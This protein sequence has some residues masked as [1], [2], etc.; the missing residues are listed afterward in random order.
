MSFF[1]HEDRDGLTTA[2]ADL[3]ALRGSPPPPAEFWP[4]LLAALSRACGAG[5]SV[6]LL[7]KDGADGWQKFADW[8]S[9]NERGAF[10]AEFAQTAP[11]L[12]DEAVTSGSALAELG[13][14]A[15]GRGDWVAVVRLLS[16]SD[17][18]RCVMACLLRDATPETARDRVARLL[19]LA[20]APAVCEGRIQLQRA[21][22]DV[23]RFSS[24]VDLMLAMRC[25]QRFLAA[26][27]TF[28]NELASRHGCGRVALGWLVGNRY[29]RVQAISHTEKFEGKMEAVRLLA[30]A[31]EEALDQDEEILW[32]KPGG[33]AAIARDHAA[34]AKAQG[35]AFLCSLPLRDEGRAVGVVTCERQEAAF[36]E[37]D[38]RLLRLSCDLAAAQ[39]AGLKKRDRW[40]GA[41]WAAAAR[42]GL[43]RLLGAEHTWA[44]VASLAGCA[45]LAV[46]CFG[47][48]PYR[49]E[50][51]FILRTDD[52][53]YLPAPFDGY[54]EEV[55]AEVGDPVG[56]D[57]PLLRLDTRDLRLEEAAALADLDRYEREA[58]KAR[59][60]NRLA[61]MRIAGAQAEQARARLDLV[62]YRLEQSA[63]RAPFAGVVVEGRLK[64]RTGS[65]VEKGDI[66]FRVVRAGRLYAEC[67]VDE[68]DVQEV[69]GDSTGEIA[70][71]GEPRL[72]FP[73]RV[74]RVDPMAQSRE[75]GNIFTVRCEAPGDVPGW[76]RPGL[77]GVA[78]I[79][80][81]RRTILWIFTHRTVDF[82]RM[83]LWW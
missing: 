23:A 22:E 12:A 42:A 50:A 3:R 2:V 25:Q 37:A 55:L 52:V 36:S 27:M 48:M 40:F 63:V 77:S 65:P 74:A 53:V 75:E 45:A 66:L 14:R 46:L 49:V 15:A 44:K 9:E 11:G 67:S 76:W 26:A 39:L 54:I 16:G 21:C 41:R 47:R 35:A 8:S 81:G 56:G 33:G 69:A 58:E 1:L 38:V 82:L 13:V 51:P 60:D 6:L 72:K 19:L 5:R 78:K 73:V 30:A 20:D 80:A 57:K 43:A 59:A 28:C 68:T 4:R 18:D 24:A 29:V 17:A 79:D 64:D 10:A 71:A 34:H 31:M 7:R 62:R 32:P 70:F 61:D 83:K